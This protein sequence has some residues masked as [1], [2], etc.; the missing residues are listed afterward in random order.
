[1]KPFEEVPDEESR[2][3]VMALRTAARF[4]PAE[5]LEDPAETIIDEPAEPAV[6]ETVAAEQTEKPA[7]SAPDELEN[8][9]NQG[10]QFLSGLMQMATG[11]P[12][13]T[14]AAVEINRE[15][16][17]VVFRFKLPE[18]GKQAR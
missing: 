18:S 12:L 6:A 15:T 2:E 8:T 17:E 16:G 9:L 3:S 14:D 7:Q 13:V 1:M 10:L 4:C 11:K 5:A